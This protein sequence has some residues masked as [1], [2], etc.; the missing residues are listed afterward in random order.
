MLRL[1]VGALVIAL[2]LAACSSHPSSGIVAGSVVGLISS[3]DGTCVNAGP[4]V[5]NGQRDEPTCFTGPVGHR[6]QCGRGSPNT[7]ALNR[8]APLG[9]PV[10]S[11]AKL[12]QSRCA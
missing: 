5:F 3:A 9:F 12:P 2:A 8:G 7:P 6:G 11:V 1:S 10:D 4:S